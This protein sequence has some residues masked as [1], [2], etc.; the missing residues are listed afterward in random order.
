MV[1]D[2]IVVDNTNIDKRSLVRINPI[3]LSALNLLELWLIII[4]IMI[5]ILC[6]YT[7]WLI[8][9]LLMC[10]SSTVLFSVLLILAVVITIFVPDGN[11]CDILLPMIRLGLDSNMSIEVE[12]IDLG[13]LPTKSIIVSNYPSSFVE[14]L[15]I[16]SVLR[17]YNKKSCI[18][19]GKTA[20]FWASLFMD[21]ESLFV[22]TGDSKNF[23]S[24]SEHIISSHKKDIVPIIYPEKDF[25][26]RKDRADIQE[27]R[28]GIFKIAE[29]YDYNIIVIHVQHIE[30]FCGFMTKPT[31][32]ISTAYSITKSPDDV[33]S[34]MI[35]MR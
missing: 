17:T 12:G 33:R 27:F 29:K 2:D 9:P 4:L 32:K 20:G 6:R 19:V 21:R 3:Y 30:H 15:L 10:I 22:L 16:P 5:L 23:E 35:K 13:S 11:K 7:S 8:L 28:S 31:I 18:V 14:Y 25:W 1:R 24:L 26:K 34:Q